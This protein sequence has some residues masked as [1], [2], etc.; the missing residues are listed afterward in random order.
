MLKEKYRKDAIEFI[1]D[2][3]AGECHLIYGKPDVDP[4]KQTRQLRGV[5][6]EMARRGQDAAGRIE[7]VRLMGEYATYDAHGWREQLLYSRAVVL[8][9]RYLI[10]KLK[11][12]L[13]PPAPRQ[14]ALF[15]E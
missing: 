9:C 5:I 13:P 8:A 15:E 2:W 7:W 10:R 4:E 6:H 11:P 3:Q 14:A 12:L 1:T